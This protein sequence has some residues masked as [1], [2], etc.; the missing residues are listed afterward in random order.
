MSALSVFQYMRSSH[1]ANWSCACS[2]TQNSH[3][4]C[5]ASYHSVCN[6]ESWHE[7]LQTWNALPPSAKVPKSHT[8]VSQFIIFPYLLLLQSGHIVCIYNAGWGQSSPRVNEKIPCIF[9]GLWTRC[10]SPSPSQLTFLLCHGKQHSENQPHSVNSATEYPSVKLFP[11]LSHAQLFE[12]QYRFT[13]CMWWLRFTLNFS[14]AKEKCVTQA[15]LP[16][17]NSVS[18]ISKVYIR[19]TGILKIFP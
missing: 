11:S 10:I 12:A 19:I 7:D 2:W 3:P 6:T 1:Y 16:S 18:F 5:K 4:S 9:D 14:M 15:V 17:V 13:I 8:P